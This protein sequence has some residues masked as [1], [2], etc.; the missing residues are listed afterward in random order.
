[1]K[2]H[3]TDFISLVSGAILLTVVLVYAI[4]SSLD[5]LSGAWIVAVVLLLAG[6]A[7]LA[8]TTRRRRAVAGGEEPSLDLPGD[9]FGESLGVSAP[10]GYTYPTGSPAFPPGSPAAA[11]H[12]EAAHTSGGGYVTGSV[13]G[14][15]TGTATDTADTRA[16]ADLSDV[17]PHEHADEPA[18][19]IDDP[20]TIDPQDSPPEKRSP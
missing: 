7:G 3:S 12:T 4:A 2:R 13:T 9:P 15:V 1:V 18:D 17:A 14:S 10:A 16:T 6:A 8:G 20:T 11:I 19:A 5:D